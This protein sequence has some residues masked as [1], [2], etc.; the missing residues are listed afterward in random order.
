MFSPTY[1]AKGVVTNIFWIAYCLITSKERSLHA[2][3]EVG[4]YLELIRG[5]ELPLL[6][7]VQRRHIDTARNETVTGDLGDRLQRTLNAV[8][9]VLHD[10]CGK[11]GN[12]LYEENKLYDNIASMLDMSVLCFKALR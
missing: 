12:V 1:R 10:S 4:R 6:D 5:A 9:D 7:D 3:T 8:K 11:Y 2:G